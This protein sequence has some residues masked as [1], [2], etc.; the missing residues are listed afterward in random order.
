MTY[1]GSIN[2]ISIKYYHHF[3]NGNYLKLLF[4]FK[5]LFYL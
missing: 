2:Q 4:S 3:P 1:E 5:M